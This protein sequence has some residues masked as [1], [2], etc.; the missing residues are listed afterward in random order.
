MAHPL[1]SSRAK[2]KRAK[3]H[4]GQLKVWLKSLRDPSAHLVGIYEDP[5][6]GQLSAKLDQLK[7][8]E[9]TVPLIIGDIVHNLRSALDH[10]AFHLVFKD[11]GGNGIPV[12]PG[13]DPFKYVYFP[14]YDSASEYETGKIGKIKGMSQ[15]SIDAVDAA[16]PYK[17]GNDMLWLIHKLDNIDKHRL[18]IALCAIRSS[19]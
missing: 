5:Q 4:F 9:E 7:E 18:L 19:Y 12:K 3:K 1:D 10:I 15:R 16:K 6:T 2:T 8:I 11:T 13:A 14:I 17:G